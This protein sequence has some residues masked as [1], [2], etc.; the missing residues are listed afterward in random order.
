ML[1]FGTKL[2][3]YYRFLKSQ[4]DTLENAQFSKYC[5]YRDGPIP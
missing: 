4:Q 3:R 1:I 2:L 5:E